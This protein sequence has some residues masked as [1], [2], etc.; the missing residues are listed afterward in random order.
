MPSVWLRS[1]RLSSLNSEKIE[2]KQKKTE[3]RAVMATRYT[4]LGLHYLGRTW[5]CAQFLWM[6][7]R[8]CVSG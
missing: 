3:H 7:E 6:S 4:P 5:A 1:L 8:E 2:W